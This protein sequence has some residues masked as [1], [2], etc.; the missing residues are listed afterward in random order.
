MKLSHSHET[1]DTRETKQAT[2]NE[3][4][5]HD[6]FDDGSVVCFIRSVARSHSL[7][8]HALLL[9]LAHPHSLRE[10]EPAGNHVVGSHQH[11]RCRLE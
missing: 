4:K 8:A 6:A 9:T 11:T 2:S 5:N 10:P 7:I 1:R 3:A